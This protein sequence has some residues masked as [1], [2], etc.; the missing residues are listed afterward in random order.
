MLNEIMDLPDEKVFDHM[1]SHLE[2][3]QDKALLKFI[4]KRNMPTVPRDQLVACRDD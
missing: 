4:R 1:Y 3:E 2:K